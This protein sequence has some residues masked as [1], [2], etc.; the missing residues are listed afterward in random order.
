MIGFASTLVAGELD[1]GYLFSGPLVGVITGMAMLIP[2]AYVFGLI[3]A[4]VAALA[5][6][7]IQL[8]QAKPEWLWVTLFGTIIGFV[9]VPAFGAALGGLLG[10]AGWSVADIRK[11]AFLAYVPTCL[12]PTL[13]CWWLSRWLDK[14][15]QPSHRGGTRL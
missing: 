11:E 8:R 12:I 15:V 6:R 14:P 10:S 3:P 1:G 7:Q 13:V 5:V 4:L 2:F 9:F